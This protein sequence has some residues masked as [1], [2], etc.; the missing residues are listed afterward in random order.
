MNKMEAKFDQLMDN[1][2][3]QMRLEHFDVPQHVLICH[4][5]KS[6]QKGD[7]GSGKTS[8]GKTSTAGFKLI[9]AAK[10]NIAEA[11][12]ARPTQKDK[13]KPEASK[14]SKPEAPKPEP[15]QPSVSQK[16]VGKKG[17]GKVDKPA[18][19]TFNVDSESDDEADKV[20]IAVKKELAK[21]QAELQKQE[22]SARRAQAQRD[23]E[24]QLM[25]SRYALQFAELK[26]QYAQLDDERKMAWLT[27][28]SVG[29]PNPEPS[30]Q[31]A[32]I[33]QFAQTPAPAQFSQP[34]PLA[35]EVSE[36][37]KN[38]L[39]EKVPCRSSHNCL[40]HVHPQTVTSQVKNAFL[41]AQQEAAA[42][43]EAAQS[44]FA[45]KLLESQVRFAKLAIALLVCCFS[46]TSSPPFACRLKLHCM[47]AWRRQGRPF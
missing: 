37:Q 45:N 23:A 5:S 9:E 46:M 41:T 10:R 3:S 27:S 32:Q 7:W 39:E 44:E 11:K 15:N 8:Y 34:P 35:P 4:L 42:K 30:S 19:S 47:R 38:L 21:A 18:S 33:V 13:P 20:P 25:E 17:R 24:L 1:V 6:S 2:R 40:S 28:P 14:P 26:R 36:M 22:A 16:E 43:L 31:N 12:A 29:T